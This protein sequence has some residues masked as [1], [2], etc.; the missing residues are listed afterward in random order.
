MK[1][2][3]SNMKTKLMNFFYNSKSESLFEKYH[4]FVIILIDLFLLIILFMC[5]EMESRII[6]SLF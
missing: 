5:D 6:W 4:V 1:E 2:I 3:F